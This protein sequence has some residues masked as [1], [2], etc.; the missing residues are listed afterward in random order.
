V[1]EMTTVGLSSQQIPRSF[2]F[3]LRTFLPD[4]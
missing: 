2:T 1:E 4:V 3:P